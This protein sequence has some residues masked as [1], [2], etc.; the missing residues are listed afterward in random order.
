[1][2]EAFRSD[3]GCNVNIACTQ[4]GPR[5]TYAIDGYVGPEDFD[6]IVAWLKRTDLPENLLLDFDGE[7]YTFRTR[8][9]RVCFARGFYK[10]FDILDDPPDLSLCTQAGV[11]YRILDNSGNEEGLKCLKELVL[12]EL[13]L[14]KWVEHLDDLKVYSGHTA[15]LL[16]L[17]SCWTT[18]TNRQKLALV[19]RVA[20]YVAALED[21]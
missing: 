3:L 7:R 21:E 20:G 9:E 1:M 15:Q 6:A 5:P 13:F 17:E 14:T 19:Q 12:K 4:E 10:A 16:I 8:T 2:D 11:A 18:L